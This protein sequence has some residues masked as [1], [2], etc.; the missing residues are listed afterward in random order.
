M[1]TAM[2]M[3]ALAATAV[4]FLRWG[5]HP[6]ARANELQSRRL[7]GMSYSASVSAAATSD[8]H[9]LMKECGPL[10][11]TTRTGTPG[12]WPGYQEITTP[13]NCSRIVSLNVDMGHGLPHAPTEIPPSM[14]SAFTMQGR[15]PVEKTYYDNMIN[16]NSGKVSVW[17][18]A[19]IADMIT[20]CAAGELGG[21]YDQ[22]ETAALFDS[23]RNAPG[24]RGGRVLV[25]G[26]HIPWVEACAL[27]AG[28][29]STVTLEYG[30]IRS[31][32]TRVDVLL[33][34]AF[35]EQ[36]AS[37]T[38]GTFDSVVT[39]SSVEHSGLGRYGDLVHPFG[40]IIA[41]ARG[42]CVTKPGGSLVIGVPTAGV[43]F[44]GKERLVWNGHRVYGAVRYPFLTQNYKQ[45]SRGKGSQRV[46][47]FTKLPHTAA[48]MAGGATA[49]AGVHTGCSDNPECVGVVPQRPGPGYWCKPQNAPL[50]NYAPTRGHSWFDA[51]GPVETTLPPECAPLTVFGKGDGEKRLCGGYVGKHSAATSRGCALISIGCNGEWSYEQSA[52]QN[53]SCDIHTFDCTGDFPIPAELRG[54]VTLHKMCIGTKAAGL[55]VTWKTML[56]LAGVSASKPLAHLKMDIEG[57]EWAVLPQM[58]DGDTSQLPEQISLELHLSSWLPVEMP[59]PYALLPGNEAQRMQLQR[60]GKISSPNRYI[61]PT[62]CDIL[63]LFNTLRAKGGYTIADRHDN[64]HCIHCTEILLVRAASPQNA[65]VPE[66][67]TIGAFG[68]KEGSVVNLRDAAAPGGEDSPSPDAVRNHFF[69]R[70]SRLLLPLQPLS[71]VSA[72]FL[73]YRCPRNAGLGNRLMGLLGAAA[74]AGVTE[75]VLLVDW[76]QEG[77]ANSPHETM[78]MWPVDVFLQSPFDYDWSCAEH[79][80]QCKAAK[81]VDVTNE[82]FWQNFPHAERAVAIDTYLNLLPLAAQHPGTLKRA[83]RGSM[84]NS[85]VAEFVRAIMRPTAG[86][87]QAMRRKRGALDAG[88]TFLAIHLRLHA[89]FTEH[90]ETQFMAKIASSRFCEH[91]LS[92]VIFT[93]ATAAEKAS[94]LSR[95]EASVPCMQFLPGGASRSTLPGLMDAFAE[96][97]LMA[98]ADVI[99]VNTM[100][101]FSS[102]AAIWGGTPYAHY[103]LASDSFFS[104]FHNAYVYSAESD[105]KKHPHL[106]LIGSIGSEWKWL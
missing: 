45:H 37:G 66:A 57:W 100:S 64:P 34:S 17:T 69:D 50:Y 92:V 91:G 13:V 12:Q 96:L 79:P 88:K 85:E 61:I 65:A 68:R 103:M 83:G 89:P 84:R 43:S 67:E 74:V 25:I 9:S 71:F 81:R 35:K 29:K 14:M 39:F 18:A 24:L 105:F 11:D 27:A 42:W 28:A 75:R 32:D 7:N 19:L 76:P 90:D 55:S 93:D 15:L 6:L 38:L 1:K 80:K 16:A 95:F 41:V 8:I 44:W 106:S 21:T 101:S 48:A 26:S 53:T 73:V 58:I 47:T 33:P 23:L 70:Q 36:F 87:L 56:R 62:P 51:M 86:V 102:F 30:E 20:K 82:R 78:A 22:S 99:C 54:R 40:D 2:N 49:V 104:R 4:L 46:H 97:M 10:C 59:P 72:R 52:A 77:V 31:E 60:D 3:G 5:Q 63:P 94:L 98:Q